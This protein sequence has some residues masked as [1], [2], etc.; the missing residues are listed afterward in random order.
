MRPDIPEHPRPH[1]LAIIPARGGSKGIPRKNITPLAGKPL[2]AYTIEQALATPAITRVIVS[3]DDAEIGAVAAQYGA[4]V[5][6]RP[7]ALS[8]DAASSESALLHVLDELARHENYA[9]DLVV[10]LQCTAPL[11]R[12]HDI[13]RAIETLLA[14]EAD[15]LL[16]LAPFKHFLWHAPDQHLTSLNFD[17]LK[18][19]RHQELPSLYMENG[20]IYVFKPRVLRETGNR[21]GGKIVHYAM[22]P[23]TAVDIDTLDDLALAEAI[24]SALW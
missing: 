14:Q 24:L 22:E 8:G 20:S 12:E 7:D 3:T 18:R 23:L 21:L 6:Q 4:E 9:P 5:M 13:Q 1:I 16:S 11:R 15:S 17:Y 19:P 10:F 2:L